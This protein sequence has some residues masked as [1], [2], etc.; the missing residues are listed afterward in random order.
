MEEKQLD[1][2]APLLS[3]RRFTAA[4]A[5][6]AA[7]ASASRKGDEGRREWSGSSAP[8]AVKEV[9]PPVSKSDL[10][11]GPVRNPGT[12]PFVW[13]SVPGKRK[14]VPME[15]PVSKPNS[16]GRLQ[17]QPPAAP[18]LP[19][20]RMVDGEK[21]RGETFGDDNRETGKVSWLQ[22]DDAVES[23]SSDRAVVAPMDVL[24]QNSVSKA[25][26]SSCLEE[27]EKMKDNLEE[28]EDDY[29]AYSDALDRLSMA[30]L[31]LFN[32]SVSDLSV[33][34]GQELEKIGNSDLQGRSFMMERFLPAAKAMANETPKHVPRKQHMAGEPAR[35][36]NKFRAE[37]DSS[38][39]QKK[40]SLMHQLALEAEEE[41]ADDEDD[42]DPGDLMAKS[43]GFIPWSLR[44]SLCPTNPL[45]HDRRER[46]KKQTP[47]NFASRKGAKSNDS[48][49]YS[50]SDELTWEAVYKN[51]LIRNVLA[52]GV[53]DGGSKLSESNSSP[54][55][56]EDTTNNWSDSQTPDES[57]SCRRSLGGISPYRN[58]A[59]NSPFREGSGFLGIPKSRK[60][61]S[62][63]SLEMNIRGLETRTNA[64]QCRSKGT[65][66][67]M[68]PAIEK[69]VYIDPISSVGMTHAKF[70]QVEIRDVN[71]IM[72]K[73]PDTWVR[74]MQK[75]VKLLP[76]S[77]TGSGDV[78]ID[79]SDEKELKNS[80]SAKSVEAGLLPGTGQLSCVYTSHGNGSEYGALM[81]DSDTVLEQSRSSKPLVEEINGGASGLDIDFPRQ[82]MTGNMEPLE[83]NTEGNSSFSHPLL[84]PPLP[85]SP[86]ESWLFRALPTVPTQNPSSMSFLQ[87][88]RKKNITKTP[89]D[90]KWET[91]IKS[92]NVYHGHL[93]YSEG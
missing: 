14:N 35:Q 90:P 24:A 87:N 39:Y 18:R 65:S 59:T 29:D 16:D 20:G 12:V 28:E 6:A 46:S 31:S 75:Q 85:K 66:G 78:D 89:A 3:V 26:V 57:V 62:S 72:E 77:Y 93:R 34:D 13:E 21:E 7:S 68:S 1:F 48:G 42:E 45:M 2:N 38:P 70:N 53:H 55:V 32:G 81:H 37:E 92:T 56:Y 91:I 67:S 73:E 43:C 9:S 79:M 86:S 8:A 49:S 76:E 30:E 19:P 64:S 25:C 11:S 84:P 15:G 54:S 17:E 40:P 4:A 52:L 10:I 71:H 80:N 47:F 63:D 27:K 51:K 58:E 61:Y 83:A 82:Q 22:T 50:G 88:R 69:T 36:V 5:A 41:D 23:V 44:S 74:E 33:L 60:S